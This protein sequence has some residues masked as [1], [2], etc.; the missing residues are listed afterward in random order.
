MFEGDF[1]SNTSLPM[2]FTDEEDHNAIRLHI[3]TA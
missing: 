1:K 2:G 3:T